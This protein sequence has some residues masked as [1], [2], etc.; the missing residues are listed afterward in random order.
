[1]AIFATIYRGDVP[2]EVEFEVD[3]TY[4]N[5]TYSSIPLTQDE[6]DDLIWIAYSVEER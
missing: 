2:V 3:I 4:W 6:V 1:M 5:L